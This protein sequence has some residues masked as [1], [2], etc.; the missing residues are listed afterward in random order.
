MGS[1]RISA[2]FLLKSLLAVAV[3]EAAAAALSAAAPLPRLWLITATRTVQL[4]VLLALAR[5][6]TGGWPML[7]LERSTLAPGIRSG[8]IWSAGFAAA[9]GLMFLGLFMAGK[10]PLAMIR[11]PLP[12]APADKALFFFV[13]GIVAPA[14]EEVVFRGLIFGY[15]RRWGLA[16]ALLISTG[17]FAAIHTGVALPVTQIVGGVVFALAYH[18][19]GS[20]MA[21]IVI[22]TLGNLAIFALSLFAA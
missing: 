3:I 16:A 2:A 14:A 5:R 13:G 9:A 15:L 1:A 11:S 6:Q 19:C 20:L 21:P 17:L 22:H 18:Q 4:A 12:A 7:G 8:L 10:N